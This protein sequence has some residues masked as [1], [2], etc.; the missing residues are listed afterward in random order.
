MD[1]VLNDFVYKVILA[2]N[3]A[4]RQNFD[5][6]GIKEYE[7]THRLVPECKNIFSEFCTK[8][9][10][11]NLSMEDT[12]VETLCKLNEKHKIY[13]VTAGFAETM[14]DREQWLKKYFPFYKY[15]MLVG[16]REKQLIKLDVLID[17]YE[18]NL[19][20]GDYKGFLVTRPWNCNFDANSN[21]MTRIEKVSDVLKYIV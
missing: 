21:G 14:G 10:M 8:R 6:Y 7:F 5:Y 19:I 1:E 9:F 16:C 20:G 11:M 2:Y 15:G 4:Y 12:A 3:K 18:K 13:F 17:D